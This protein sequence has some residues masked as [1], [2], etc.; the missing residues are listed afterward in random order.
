MQAG[1]VGVVSE[2]E[3]GDWEALLSR[4]GGGGGGTGSPGN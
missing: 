2:K 3:G 1:E 4:S